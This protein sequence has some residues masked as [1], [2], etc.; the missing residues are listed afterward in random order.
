MSINYHKKYLKYKEK[1][2]ISKTQ[3]AGGFSS[4]TNAV[5]VYFHKNNDDA[6]Q[7]FGRDN[8]KDIKTIV[9]SES[10]IHTQLKRGTC[11][12]LKLNDITDSSVLENINYK[13][14][15]D[16]KDE[17]AKMKKT[18]QNIDDK[19]TDL[20]KDI[21]AAINTYTDLIDTYFTKKNN[22]DNSDNK[23][24]LKTL[25][26][27]VLLFEILTKANTL[28]LNIND[29]KIEE[30]KTD[31]GTEAATAKAPTAKEHNDFLLAHLPEKI[32]TNLTI[33]NY[34]PAD[35]ANIDSILTKL[36]ILDDDIKNYFI[37]VK[38]ALGKNLLLYAG[39][40]KD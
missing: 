9:Q 39:P 34:M 37:I 29:F 1:Y 8:P 40:K 7:K 28:N 18:I 16:P 31:A 3:N 12:R 4:P 13:K 30:A 2:L 27:K 35:I 10:E 5:Y 38:C 26:Q 36:K 21:P 25:L 19:I 23:P 33:K 14:P 15:D 20:K 22:I 17:I 32:Y 11:I 6:Y 24:E